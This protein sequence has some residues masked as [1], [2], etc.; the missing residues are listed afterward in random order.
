MIWL[1]VIFLVGLAWH[2]IATRRWG[3]LIFSIFIGLGTAIVMGG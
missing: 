1:F 2:G 3:Q